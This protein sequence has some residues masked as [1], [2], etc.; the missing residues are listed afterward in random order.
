VDD[1]L[2]GGPD[3]V[4]VAAKNAYPEYKLIGAYIC[5]PE[6]ERTF[7][8]Q[9]SRLGFYANGAIQPEVPVIQARRGEVEIS[10]ENAERLRA[11][12]DATDRSFAD[13]IDRYMAT[14]TYAKSTPT[15]FPA[16]VFL[17]APPDDPETV[18]FASPIKN[19]TKAHTGRGYGWTLKQRYT[20]S[21][22]LRRGPVTT[23]DLAAFRG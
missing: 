5:Q 10:P 13:V 4:I 9:I 6:S 15:P 3:V 14:S 2:L 1:D 12:G 22:A 11:T 20:R 19:T 17:L 8:P 18:L 16:Q 7:Q 21:E 23:D